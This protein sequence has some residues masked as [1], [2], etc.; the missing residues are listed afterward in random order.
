MCSFGR[1]SWFSDFFDEKQ[2]PARGSVVREKNIFIKYNFVLFVESK[3]TRD[4][5]RTDDESRGDGGS[6]LRAP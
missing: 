2:P 1:L 6:R 4:G 3:G 5:N